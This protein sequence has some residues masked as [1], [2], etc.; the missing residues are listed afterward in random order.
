V[1][2]GPSDLGGEK[3]QARYGLGSQIFDCKKM[4]RHVQTDSSKWERR[5]KTS[6]GLSVQFSRKYLFAARTVE[7]WNNLPDDIKS[8]PKGEV[9]RRRLGKLLKGHG[10]E[11][12]F[13]GFLHKPARHRSFTLHFEPFLF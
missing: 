7:K 4:N 10:N 13:L 1:R 6:H 5:N 3:I 9:L 8:A 12:D 2:T 11:A